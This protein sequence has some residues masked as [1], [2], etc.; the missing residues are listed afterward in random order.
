MTVNTN[1]VHQILMGE[2]DEELGQILKAAKRRS[3][4]VHQSKL[5]EAMYVGGRI[6]LNIHTRPKYMQGKTGTITKINRTTAV[7]KWDE[8]TTRFGEQCKV[9][10]NLLDP[11]SDS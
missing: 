3:D 1:I 5:D 8:T 10:F 4:F 6:K 7:I 11:I 9:P 2:Y